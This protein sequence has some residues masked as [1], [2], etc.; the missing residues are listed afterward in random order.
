MR[1]ALDR[2]LT[3]AA[4]ENKNIMVVVGDVS[5]VALGSFTKEFPD[6]FINVGI[7]EANLVGTGAGLAFSGKIPF[8]FTIATFMIYRCYEQ[9]RDDLCFQNLNV[10][11][12][13]GGG[14]FIYST[15]GATHHATEDYAVL[16]AL[17]NMTVVA[18]IDPFEVEH[19]VRAVIAHSG[20]AYIRLGRSGDTNVYTEEEQKNYQFVL[21]KGVVL[22]EGK[23]VA[24]IGTGSVLK[25]ALPAVETLKEMGLGVRVINMHTVKPLDE[26]LV[27]RSARECGAIVTLEEHQKNGGLGSAVAEVLSER[28]VSVPFRRMGVNNVFLNNTYGSRDYLLEKAGLG[29]ERI[30]ETVNAVYREKA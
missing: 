16:R 27:E 17:P 25:N 15:L 2:A 19:A 10:K 8:L 26:E 22:R 14:G 11:L 5:P 24:L 9:I 18:P 3:A 28:K 21:G 23:D 7:A 13:G 20:P 6:R 30:V 12:V 4:Q 29:V 1:A